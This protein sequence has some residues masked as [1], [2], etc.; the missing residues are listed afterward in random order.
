MQVNFII[1]FLHCTSKWCLNAIS[2]CHYILNM[3]VTCLSLPS[4]RIS[5]AF[6]VLP[7]I[8]SSLILAGHIFLFALI[9]STKVKY[10]PAKSQRTVLKVWVFL[11]WNL[12]III[13]LVGTCDIFTC[14]GPPSIVGEMTTPCQ[15]SNVCDIHAKLRMWGTALQITHCINKQLYLRILF[16]VTW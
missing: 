3:M 16:R 11:Y 5:I 4:S 8:C 14:S 1:I 6:L 12:P 13:R 9:S 7:S 10:Y 2:F 15:C